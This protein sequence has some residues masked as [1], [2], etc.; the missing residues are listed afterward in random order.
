MELRAGRGGRARRRRVLFVVE[1][2]GAAGAVSDGSRWPAVPRAGGEAREA[3]ARRG[4]G[5]VSGQEDGR[6]LYEDEA[7]SDYSAVGHQYIVRLNGHFN[8]GTTIAVG[9]YATT[10]I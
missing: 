8:S 3:H 2:Q 10:G 5:A 9:T 4:R 6:G 7:N 1:R